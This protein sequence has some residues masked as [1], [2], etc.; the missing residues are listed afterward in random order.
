LIRNIPLIPA[1]TASLRAAHIDEEPI[2]ADA[3]EKNFLYGEEAVY[4]N[5]HKLDGTG[6]MVRL[7]MA[8]IA[9]T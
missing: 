6:N 3:L 4:L 8:A 9:S 5:R 7:P 2:L 1:D